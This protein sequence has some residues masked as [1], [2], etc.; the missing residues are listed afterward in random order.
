M[1]QLRPL[2]I[3]LETSAKEIWEDALFPENAKL[4]KCK[5]HLLVIIMI[6]IR[7]GQFEKKGMC[8]DDII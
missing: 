8:L 6:F 7:E 3:L 2:K 1:T 4:V 5:S